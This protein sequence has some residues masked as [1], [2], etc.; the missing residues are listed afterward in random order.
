[1]EAEGIV[2]GVIETLVAG[3]RH[4]RFGIS[5]SHHRV[6]G[7]AAAYFHSWAVCWDLRINWIGLGFE[8]AASE[9][10]PLFPV[11]LHGAAGDVEFA[12]HVS[13]TALGE[14]DCGGDLRE[15]SDD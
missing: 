1:M 7:A 13:I 3:V 6:Y 12:D 8:L 5:H 10:F 2:R 4:F 9:F 14:R 11:C 15:R